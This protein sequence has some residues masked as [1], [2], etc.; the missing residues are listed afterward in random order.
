MATATEDKLQDLLKDFDA[1]MLVTRTTDGQLRSRPMMLAEVDANGGLWFVTGG[2]SGKIEELAHDHHV[3]VAMQSKWK[4]VSI[5]GRAK[6]TD[7]STPRI[8][9]TKYRPTIQ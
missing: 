6:R 2:D 5:S 9:A 1:A 8:K 7:A 4:F 3:N